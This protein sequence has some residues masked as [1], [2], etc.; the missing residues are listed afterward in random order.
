[1]L[2]IY[3]SII[4]MLPAFKTFCPYVS[5]HSWKNT[6][7]FADVNMYLNKF[8]ILS[9]CYFQFHELL[10]GNL[11]LYCLFRIFFLLIALGQKWILHMTNKSSYWENCVVKRRQFA[12]LLSEDAQHRLGWTTMIMKTSFGGTAQIN[13]GSIQV[14]MCDYCQIRN[15][16]IWEYLSHKIYCHLGLVYAEIHWFVK[17]DPSGLCYHN[18]SGS[19]RFKAILGISILTA[20]LTPKISLFSKF[21]K[22]EFLKFPQNFTKSVKT[23]PKRHFWK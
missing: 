14:R 5:G 2:N 11:A 22:Y 21:S 3:L 17:S 4:Y 13:K 6:F 9:W 15:L 23:G 20:R 18:I 8:W 12:L 10:L 19:S 1:M 7:L 16:K